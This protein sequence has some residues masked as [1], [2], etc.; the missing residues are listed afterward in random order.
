MTFLVPIASRH[1]AELR[2]WWEIGFWDGGKGPEL[3]A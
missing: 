3:V 1:L 2:P